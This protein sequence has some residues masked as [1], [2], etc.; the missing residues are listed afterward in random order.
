[1]GTRDVKAVDRGRKQNT[2]SRTVTSLGAEEL[3]IEYVSINTEKE[4]KQQKSTL[5]KPLMF[6]KC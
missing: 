5:N 4:N 6:N 1:M 3:A 2:M